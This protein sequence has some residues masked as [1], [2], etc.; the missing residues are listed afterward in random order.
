MST[1][2]TAYK[3]LEAGL[4]TL[5]ESNA[6]MVFPDSPD[7]LA[8][9]RAWYRK[10][11]KATNALD[12]LRKTEK[13]EYLR[14]GREVD[15]EAKTIQTRL[16][17]ME[18]PHKDILDAEDARLQKEI[19]DLAEK[20]RLE[21][22][23][24][25]AA[26][27]KDLEE[28]E[29]KAQAIIDAA[30]KVEADRIAEQEAAERAKKIE[31]DKLAA[32]EEA[33]RQAEQDAKDAKEKAERE[34][35]AAMAEEKRKAEA[36]TAR[37]KKEIADKYK[38]EQ[39]E[40]ARLEKIEAERIADENYRCSVKQIIFDAIIEKVGTSREDTEAIVDAIAMDEIPHLTIKY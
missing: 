19:D 6:S 25:E 7:G 33:K 20:N 34:K 17:V 27:L 13:A 10:L 39:D 23:A 1:E 4:S 21:A 30:A 14:L 9:R 40:K 11:R 35:Q 31:A 2:I 38:A 36:E 12:K 28:R 8:E 5:E 15:S 26:R 22:E 37:I 16:D 29:T 18:K 24:K 3:E 32:V